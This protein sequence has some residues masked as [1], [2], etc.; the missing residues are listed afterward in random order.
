M[1][2]SHMPRWAATWAQ[3]PGPAAQS[4][5]LRLLAHVHI[6]LAGAPRSDADEAAKVYVSVGYRASA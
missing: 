5:R 3:K 6:R 1:R 2:Q 4:A